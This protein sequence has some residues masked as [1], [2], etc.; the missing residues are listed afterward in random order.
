MLDIDKLLEKNPSVREVFE[1]NQAIIAN[2]PRAKRSEY[3]LGLPYGTCRP[4][5]EPN[6]PEPK[7]KA[8]YTNR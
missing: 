3:R 6:V 1:K 7:P 8:S 5:A 4:D 2:T